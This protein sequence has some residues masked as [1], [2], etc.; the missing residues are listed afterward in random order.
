MTRSLSAGIVLPVA[1]GLV[2]MAG[3]THLTPTGVHAQSA[4]TGTPEATAVPIVATAAPGGAPPPPPTFVPT[5]IGAPPAP[6]TDTPT[7][8][9]TPAP[10]DTPTVAPTTAP[11]VSTPTPQPS[12][13]TATPTPTPASLATGPP[14]ATAKPT[15]AP[16]QPKGGPTVAPVPMIPSGGAGGTFG[17]GSMGATKLSSVVM[18]IGAPTVN[19]RVASASPRAL[20]RTGGGDGGNPTAPLAPLALLGALAIGTGRLLHRFVNR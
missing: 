1:A 10:T 4:A 11:Q 17:R 18:S 6:P 2:A 12:P 14:A 9:P 3:A 13:K 7:V 5:A 16:P 19:G 8:T 20:P 15:T